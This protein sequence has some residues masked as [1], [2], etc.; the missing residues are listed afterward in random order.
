[1]STSKYILGHFF[2][3]QRIQEKKK[4]FGF[5]LNLHLQDD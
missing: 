5:K 4:F 3:L 2:N 1:M